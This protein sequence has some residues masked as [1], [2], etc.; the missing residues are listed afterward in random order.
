M[1]QCT[2]RR[3]AALALLNTAPLSAKEG[4]F[5]GQMA[6]A[7]QMTPKQARWFD[8]LLERHGLSALEASTEIDG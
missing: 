3:S 2:S 1:S 4:G 8:I 6:F 7:D 5:V